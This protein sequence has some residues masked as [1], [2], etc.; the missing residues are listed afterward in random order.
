[1]GLRA[2]WFSAVIGV[3]GAII[4]RMLSEQL[5]GVDVR[6]VGE[7]LMISG[8]VGL[9][10]SSFFFAVSL[11]RGERAIVRPHP[12]SI[13]TSH[14]TR[15]VQIPGSIDLSVHEAIAFVIETPSMESPRHDSSSHREWSPPSGY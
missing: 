3:I 4:W 6:I 1:M 13:A 15:Q 12:P 7:I 9:V 8:A 2:M 11:R 5:T 14:E 10:V